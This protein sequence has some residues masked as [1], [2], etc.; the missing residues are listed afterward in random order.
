MLSLRIQSM[1]EWEG[2]KN[3]DRRRQHT[4]SFNAKLLKSD[5]EQTHPILFEILLNYDMWQNQ[6]I[7]EQ[8]LHK[9]Y[10]FWLNWACY[11]L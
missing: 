5:T 2:G 4:A 9:I 10:F 8:L 1:T 11:S 7:M 3:L 6:C